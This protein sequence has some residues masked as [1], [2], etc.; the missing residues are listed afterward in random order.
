MP[1]TPEVILADLQEKLDQIALDRR[2]KTHFFAFFDIDGTLVDPFARQV[3]IYEEILQPQFNLPP[4]HELDLRSK[5][6]FIGSCVPELQTDQEKY[7]EVEQ[8]FLIHFLSPD[9]L[10]YDQP[11]P[12]SIQLIESIR[13]LGLGIIYLTSRHLHGPKSM[14]DKTIQL[15]GDWGF[16]IG[17]SI[18]VLFGFKNEIE[19][20]DLDF[21][22]KFVEKFNA[23]KFQACLFAADNEAAMCM[24]FRETF[25]EAIVVRFES[26]Q[27]QDVVFDGP[28]ITSW[29]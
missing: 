4:T 15:L 1:T 5:P 24:M 3:A 29:E 18:E 20:V 28:T 12:G 25:P 8:E 16:P 14:A 9:Y 22:Q 10:E 26:A 27:S 23:N 19:D 6:Y 13:A 7:A 2:K 21:K 17:P 11:F